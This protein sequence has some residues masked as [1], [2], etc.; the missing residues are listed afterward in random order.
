MDNDLDD[1]IQSQTESSAIEFK[2]TF[3]PN[4]AGAWCEIIKDIVAM[5]NSGG[6][7]ILFGVSD[8]GSP[9]YSNF[10]EINEIDPSAFV[11]KIN[12]YTGQIYAGCTQHKVIR[13]KR[14]ITALLIQGVNIPMIFTSPGT[15]PTNDGKQKSA[16]SAGTVYFRH[17]AKSEP[18]TTDDLRLAI[19]RELDRIRSSWLDGIS[20]VVTSPIGTVFSTTPSEVSLSG[21]T[22]ATSVRLVNDESAPAFKAFRTDLL[23]PYRQKELMIKVNTLIGKQTVAA[24]DIYAVRKHYSIDAN[25]TFFY[26]PQYSSPQYSDAFANWL[27]EEHSRDTDFF[28]K[29]KDLYRKSL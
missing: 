2:S 21:N 16:F 27:H 10:D 28:Q 29:A 26:K 6:G 18:G 15:Y 3:E 14:E 17:G 22:D 9:S 4:L 20:K 1:L 5:S 25:P 24:H 8:D 7:I 11:E 12:K 23:Y 13:N 19:E